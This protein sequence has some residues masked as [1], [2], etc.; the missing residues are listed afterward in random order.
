V[1]RFTART[2]HEARDP[3]PSICPERVEPLLVALSRG[4]GNVNDLW[5]LAR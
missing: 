3:G 4:A 1:H 2:Y 5:L